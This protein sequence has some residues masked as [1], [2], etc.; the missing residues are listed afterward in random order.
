MAMGCTY[1]AG[2]DPALCTSRMS[3]AIFFRI[4]SA[5]WLR[6][7]LPVQR[8]RTVGLGVMKRIAIQPPS[9]IAVP[10]RNAKRPRPPLLPPL[11]R[12]ARANERAEDRKAE[13]AR[14]T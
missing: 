3:P 8:I 5:M 6:Q 13:L 10:G 12:P 14:E 4:P 9:N 11:D 1:P 7:E 2:L